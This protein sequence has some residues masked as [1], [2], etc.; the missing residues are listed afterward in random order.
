MVLADLAGIYGAIAAVTVAGACGMAL[1]LLAGPDRVAS[2]VATASLLAVSVGASLGAGE[3]LLRTPGIARRLGT[4]QERVARE[5]TYDRLWERNAFGYRS[6]HETFEK[7]PR[8]FRVLA[9]GDSFTWG[10]GIASSDDTWPAMLEHRLHSLIADRAVEVINLGRNGFTTANEAELLRRVGWQFQP[11]AVVVQFFRN[12]VLPSGPDFARATSSYVS[13][14]RTLVPASLRRGRIES[15]ALLHA[16]EDRYS[17][18]RNRSAT[19]PWHDLYRDDFV[20]WQQLAAAL[21]EMGDAARA[22][23][24]PIYLVIYPALL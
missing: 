3:A 2:T 5:A 1:A 18:W 14:R 4:P 22:R 24:V 19:D 8:T 15:S 6:R 11:D 16:I 13:P 20:G 21:R 12:D 7:P 17:I 10:D 23:A 9:I